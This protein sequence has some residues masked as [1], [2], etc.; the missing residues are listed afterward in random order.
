M[1]RKRLGKIEGSCSSGCF[2]TPVSNLPS[3]GITGLYPTDT[4]GT[5]GLNL[6][7]CSDT[8]FQRLGVEAEEQKLKVISENIKVKGQNKTKIWKSITPTK[9]M[10]PKSLPKTWSKQKPCS[11]TNSLL[12]NIPSSKSLQ[13]ALYLLSLP[14]TG[15]F[16]HHLES[17]LP[18][19][20][21]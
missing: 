6:S 17:C 12:A 20:F 13:G 2:W 15:S 4:A 9:K 3:A 1:K 5:A 10:K 11:P 21:H 8:L 14:G 18:E 19:T 16:K 7:D